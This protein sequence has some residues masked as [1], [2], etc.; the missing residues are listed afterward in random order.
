MIVAA[1]LFCGK[2]DVAPWAVAMAAALAS[3]GLIGGNWYIVIGGVAGGLYGAW[4]DTRTAY[5][6]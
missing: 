5:V 2:R 4:R 6:H 3:K 1:V